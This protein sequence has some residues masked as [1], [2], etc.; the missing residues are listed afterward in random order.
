MKKIP[1]D[2]SNNTKDIEDF[3]VI[4]KFYQSYSNELPDSDIDKQ[5]LAASVRELNNP[6]PL[7]LPT[8]PWWRRL[9]FPVV[10][11]ST[12]A[13]SLIAASWL[14]HEPL[15]KVPPGTAPSPSNFNSV[16]ISLQQVNLDE[17]PEEKPL[18]SKLKSLPEK[19]LLLNI[20]IPSIDIEDDSI[21]LVDGLE[22]EPLKYDINLDAL[23]K[24]QGQKDIPNEEPCLVTI[25]GKEVAC[26]DYNKEKWL[27]AIKT[28]FQEDQKAAR[29]ELAK[30]KKTYSDY[31]TDK[32]LS[33]FE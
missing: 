7:I 12:F 11:V 10:A 30:F 5:I 9:A 24:R 28:L 15:V 13:F 32:D 6:K 33:E 31:L 20:E 4:E 17:I 29:V 19:P 16:D 18:S 8:R 26:E 21:N 14:W 27:Q 3:S 22:S 1:T 2:T 23:N 25:K